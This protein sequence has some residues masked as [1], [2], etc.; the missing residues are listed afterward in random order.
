MPE[1]SFVG[2]YRINLTKISS[3]NNYAM[4]LLKENPPEGAMVQTFSQ[5]S[6]RG[7]QGNT[8][9][10]APGMNLT[11]SLIF[12]PEFVRIEEIFVLSKM[13]SVALCQTLKRFL[14]GEQVQ[15]KWP[16]DIL[17]NQKKAVGILIENQLEGQKVKSS[18][19]GIGLNIN[20]THFPDEI[21]DRVTSMKKVVGRN[22]DLEEVLQ[23]MLYQIEN[24]YVKVRD[25]MPRFIDRRYYQHLYGYQ[26]DIEVMIGSERKVVSVAGVEKS[27]RL[28][29]KIDEGLHYFGFKELTFIL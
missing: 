9:V 3:T 24:V 26:E 22:F 15:I 12:Y 4:E 11:I 18:I 17:I 28:I 20:Q 6:G 25:G 7:Q 14:P 13:I 1:T 19:T 8:W 10:A 23:E 21:S 29:L 5:T 27:G 2:K 16:N